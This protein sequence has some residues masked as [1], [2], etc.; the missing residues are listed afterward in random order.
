MIQ[1][2]KLLVGAFIFC[3][4][5]K[6]SAHS[7]NFCVSGEQIAITENKIFLKQGADWSPVG[8]VTEQGI[9]LYENGTEIKPLMGCTKCEIKWDYEKGNVSVS[10]E[11]EPKQDSQ[12]EN[13]SSNE[14]EQSDTSNHD[15]EQERDREQD[16]DRW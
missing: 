3:Q 15:R 7:H 6:G 4:C 1:H 12:R 8:V 2:L 9:Y 13:D 16:H 10:V 5:A 11:R 14:R